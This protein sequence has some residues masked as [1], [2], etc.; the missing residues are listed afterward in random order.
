[1]MPPPGM[2]PPPPPWSQGDV[3]NMNGMAMQWQPPVSMPPPPGV[4]QPPPPPPGSTSQPNI[5]PLMP[6]MPGKFLFFKER[7]LK[8]IKS[9]Y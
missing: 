8:H 7:V 2:A 3:N 1:M 4:M 9:I 6:W 5:P